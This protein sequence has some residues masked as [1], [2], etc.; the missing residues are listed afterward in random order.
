ML[1]R[2]RYKAGVRG[3]EKEISKVCR[4]TVKVIETSKKNNV[5]LDTKRLQEFLGVVKYRSNEI[6]KKNLIGITNGLAWTEV[7][8]EILSV[9]LFIIINFSSSNNDLLNKSSKK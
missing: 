7:G 6:E 1:F 8:G 3:L 5:S 4:K 9:A 2:S